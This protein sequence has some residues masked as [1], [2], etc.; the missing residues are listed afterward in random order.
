M[1]LKDKA[2]LEPGGLRNLSSIEFSAIPDSEAD[3]KLVHR[4]VLDDL[5]GSVEDFVGSADGTN[6]GVTSVSGDYVGGAA[7][8]GDGVD[9][10][11]LTSTWG[12]WWSDNQH[13]HAVAFTIDGTPSDGNVIGHTDDNGENQYHVGFGNFPA[14]DEQLS[15][16]IRGSSS[17][18]VTMEVD[19]V[20]STPAR[21]V[22]NRTGSAD[23]DFKFWV[24][25]SDPPQTYTNTQGMASASAFD[26]PVA[27]FGKNRSD[28]VT[29]H[30][31][32]I[33]D[34]ICIYD[35]QLTQSEIESY[36]NPWS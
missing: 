33:V 17:D 21:V 35:S 12:S 6:N 4:W 14:N 22:L 3:Q 30:L 15:I 28:G 9:D 36:D 13:D 8:E 23:T 19:D 32:A 25:Q 31:G 24:N 20:I 18:S 27:L 5:N 26:K 2:V 1:G 29:D 34:D 16:F 10:H 11:I 7:G